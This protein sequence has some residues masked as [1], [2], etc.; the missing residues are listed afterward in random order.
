MASGIE[1]PRRGQNAKSKTLYTI[2]LGIGSKLVGY[3]VCTCSESRLSGSG[4]SGSGVPGSWLSESRLSG[5]RQSE[6]RLPGSRQSESW[7]PGPRLWGSG[8]RAG[9]SGVPVWLL[10]D[11]SLWMRSVRLLRASVVLWWHLYWRRPMGLWPWG[12]LRRTW[13]LRRTWLCCT[14]GIPRWLW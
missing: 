6:S 10:P 2:R 9:T 8:L 12:L 11:L 14:R 4:L 3:T 13:I 5:S 7:L 1:D